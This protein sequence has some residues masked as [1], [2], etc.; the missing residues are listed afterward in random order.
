VILLAQPVTDQ[1]QMIACLVMEWIV[2]HALNYAKH[3]TELLQLIAR[4]VYR[5]LEF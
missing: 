3:V 1:P 4:L 5:V 2:F